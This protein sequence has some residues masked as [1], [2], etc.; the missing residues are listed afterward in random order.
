M[1]RGDESNVG[2]AEGAPEG[3]RS[4]ASGSTREGME[5]VVG[6]CELAAKVS[7]AVFSSGTASATGQSVEDVASVAGGCFEAGSSAKAALGG[8]GAIDAQEHS[9]WVYHVV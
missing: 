9:G 2:S 5:P 8:S 7:W 1:A 4:V 6:L 3:C